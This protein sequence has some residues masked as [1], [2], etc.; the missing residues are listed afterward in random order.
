MEQNKIDFIGVGVPKAAAQF[1]NLSY[2]FGLKHL[3]KIELISQW[4]ASENFLDRLYKQINY[5][6]FEYPPMA[7]KTREILIDYYKKDITKTEKLIN[8]NLSGW[9]AH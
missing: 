5:K 9:L 2:L 7:E 8:R 3:K 1:I 4:L 6:K